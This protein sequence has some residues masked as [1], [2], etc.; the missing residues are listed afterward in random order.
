MSISSIVWSPMSPSSA[1]HV[2]SPKGLQ[3][4]SSSS[5]FPTSHHRTHLPPLSSLMASSSYA[6][7]N[8]RQSVNNTL[9]L[10]QTPITPDS[11]PFPSPAMT[12]RT[13]ININEHQHKKRRLLSPPIAHTSSSSVSSTTTIP[14]HSRAEHHPHSRRHPESDA[15]VGEPE[16]Y[17]DTDM[18]GGHTDDDAKPRR[19]DSVPGLPM[20]RRTASGSSPSIVA[21]Q[22]STTRAPPSMSV[23]SSSTGASAMSGDPSN[24]GVNKQWKTPTGHRR[25]ITVQEMLPLE[26]PTQLRRRG[27]TSNSGPSRPTSSS[28]QPQSPTASYSHERTHEH[29]DNSSKQSGP[30]K[31]AKRPR[32]ASS[33]AESVSPAHSSALSLELEP[34]GNS[35][36]GSPAMAHMPSG[37]PSYPVHHPA[38]ASQPAPRGHSKQPGGRS[39]PSPDPLDSPGNEDPLALKRRQNTI[40]A[41]RSRQRKLE[42][43]R[44]LEKQVEGL[45]R[46]RDELKGRVAR[47]EDR[48]SFLKEI[49]AGGGSTAAAVATSPRIAPRQ[50]SRQGQNGSGGGGGSSKRASTA[51][52]DQDADELYDEDAPQR[53]DDDYEDEY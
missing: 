16:D 41:R 33:F 51:W 19:A 26:A 22:P 52:E 35:E 40:A 34:E 11:P 28:G 44:S 32:T 24:L 5:S 50:A 1:H 36:F 10:T 7:S 12:D 46:E 38:T 53:D 13:P 20:P 45:T 17:P 15:M 43:V 14:S 48:V 31:P 23:L 18:S 37:G 6:S 4:P 29:P 3:S 30:S 25:G 47:L 8:G 49:V 9:H 21:R 42:H 39:D 2:A 27:S